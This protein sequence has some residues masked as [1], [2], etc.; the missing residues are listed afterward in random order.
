MPDIDYDRIAK[1]H[2]GKA[3][4][5]T[6]VDYDALAAEVG[7]AEE[8]HFRME[9]K[10]SD[11]ESRPGDGFRELWDTVNPINALAALD[12]AFRHPIDTATGMLSAQGKLAEDAKAA[13]EAGDYALGTRKFLHYLVPFLGPQLEKRGEQIDRGEYSKAFG[14]TVG[15]AINIFAPAAV[16]QVK[17][18]RAP[19]MAPQNVNAAERAA[20]EFGMREGIPVDAATATGNRFVRGTQKLADESLIGSTVGAKARQA[21]VEGFATVGDRLAAR[22][23]P[24]PV[25]AEQ[26]GQGV[27]TA[28]GRTASGHQAAADT[29]YDTLRTIERQQAQRV[30][31]TGGVQPPA[32]ASPQAFTNVPLA[33]DVTQTKAAMQPIYNALK[34]EAE[35]VPLMGDKAKALTALD[36]LMNAPDFAPLSIADSA[37]GDLK[38]VSRVTD[39]F[40]R[41]EGQGV[42]AEAVKNLEQSVRTTATKAGPDVFKALMDG[43]AA[44]VNKYKAIEVLDALRD[45]PVKVFQQLT[46]SKDGAVGLLRQV[47]R[48]APGELPKIGRA[49]LE[50]LLEK[51]KSAG[52]FEHADALFRDWQNLGV[53]TKVLLFKDPGLVSDLDKFFLLAKKTAENPNPS[54]TALTWFKGGEATLL[55]NNPA[56]GVPLSLSAAALSKLLH[57]K[58]AVRA[59]V[60]GFSIPVGNRA[61]SAAVTAELTKYAHDAGIPLVPVTAEGDRSSR[62]GSPRR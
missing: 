48:E 6:A 45:E 8:P 13:F 46:A 3:Q 23:N 54:G 49:Y 26:A 52:G 27:R 20:V 24:T 56:A 32:S 29:A 12:T 61:A 1:Q 59:M 16:S 50:G 35:L 14:G 37:L 41:T 5:P 40:R 4:G 9:V 2:G 19:R 44:T 58:A 10:A 39:A 53:N 17:A 43:R 21:Q 51:A 36:R 57:S 11:Q 22:A 7:G 30:A 62:R 33:V 38:A 31:Q 42:V 15:D 18:L 28:V 55:I 47:Q 34:R 60:R 25:T